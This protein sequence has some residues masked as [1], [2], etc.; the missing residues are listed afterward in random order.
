MTQKTPIILFVLMTMIAVHT[1]VAAP[2]V[3]HTPKPNWVL[4][5]AKIYNV[6]PEKRDIS[7]GYYISLYDKQ[8]NVD[9]ETKYYHIEKE[10]VNETGVQY[11]SEISLDFA[12]SY[13]QLYIHELSIVRDGKKINKLNLSNIKV[14]NT[15]PSLS[16]FLIYDYY[17]AIIVLEDIRKGDKIILSYSITGFNPIYDGKYDDVQ[18]FV[19]GTIITNHFTSIHIA[20]NRKLNYKAYNDAQEPNVT[21]SGNTK[22]YNWPCLYIK[23]YDYN[24]YVPGWYRG[25][26]YIEVSEYDNWGDVA[27]WATKTLY[28]PP[29]TIPNELNKLIDQWHEKANGNRQRFIEY[30]LRFVQ[31]QIRY[32]GVEMGSYSHKPHP[33]A[34]AF[35][36]R[37]GDCK[38]KSLLL[39]TILRKKGLDAHIVLVNTNIKKE[40]WS[41]IPR[42]NAFNHAIV[43]VKLGKWDYF[44]DPTMDHQRGSLTDN[45]MPDYGVGLIASN[46]TKTLKDIHF[47]DHGSTIINEAIT[48]SY[49]SSSLLEVTTI[50]S[51]WAANDTRRTLSYSSISE[52]EESYERYYSDQYNEAITTHDLDID[53][54]TIANIITIKEYYELPDP[55]TDEGDASSIS[56][57]CKS[58]Y[59][60]LPNPNEYGIDGTKPLYLTY[61]CNITHDIKVTLPEI[62]DDNNDNTTVTS[63]DYYYSAD[64]NTSGYTTTFSYTFKT[65]TDHIDTSSLTSYK[66]DY[67]KM[68]SYIQYDITIDRKLNN[69]LANLKSSDTTT[70]TNWISVFIAVIAA[71]GAF[72]I[73]FK[74][75]KRIVPVRETDYYYPINGWL[76]ILGIILSI[77]I[78][79]Y[80]Y[81]LFTTGYF[82]TESWLILNNVGNTGLQLM[83]LLEIVAMVTFII[84]SGWLLYW[85]GKRRDIFPKMFVIMALSELGIN[86]I[87]WALTIVFKENMEALFPEMAGEI[88]T[89]VVKSVFFVAIWVTAVLKSEKVKNTFVERHPSANIE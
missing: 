81:T 24:S 59:D 85:F 18:H 23:S 2:K 7:Y 45:T 1:A 4:K 10:I 67:E 17:Q 52:L 73:L 55:W 50:F 6:A 86:L 83:I 27:K 20:K 31:D 80:T 36:N 76:I 66:K 62:W 77:R 51:G 43:R 78:I 42:A 82:T 38:D 29:S 49:D 63:K 19:S 71:I 21:T 14:V 13:Q 74:Q 15:E 47:K 33:P 37:Y 5:R 8:T 56:F 28:S 12:A 64:I 16:D 57:L 32:L 35:T 88:Q 53:D 26:Q 72:L 58:I 34:T 79:V 54:D 84:F 46:N 68:I 44:F 87:Y 65:N 30:A 25:Y 70:K 41:S 89:D 3:L 69:Q 61:P 22:V 60:R 48:V 39:T 9:K 75:N 40:L 11:N